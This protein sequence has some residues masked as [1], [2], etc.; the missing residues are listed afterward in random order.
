MNRLIESISKPLQVRSPKRL[1][2]PFTVIGVFNQNG[3]RYPEDVYVGAYQEIAPK[4]KERRLLGELDHPQDYDEVRLSNVSHVITECDIKDSS[5]KKV[6]YGTV[7]LLD[8]PAGK[9]A[10]ALV[11]AG[12]PLGISSR[13]V[14]NTKRVSEGVD[15]T[16]LKLI[17]Y[18][19]VAEPSFS[20]AILSEDKRTEL[21]ESLSVIES[22]LPL[23]ESAGSDAVRDQIYKIR[24]SLCTPKTSESTEVHIDKC[25]DTQTLEIEALKS[26]VESK[27]SV[28]VEDTRRLKESRKE[29]KS[30]RTQVSDLSTRYQSLTENHQKLQDSYNS[31]KK[32]Q[33][34]AEN[35]QIASLTEEVV[36]LRKRLAVEQRGMSYE[37]VQSFLEGVSTPEEI[38]SKLDSLSAMKRRSTV[39]ES[40]GR[41]R[42]SLETPPNRS[43][44]SNIVSKV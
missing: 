20:S 23:N 1:T 14:G 33:K 24:E 29:I 16:Q 36:D 17:T 9:V 39:V 19:L 44:L 22:K 4:I 26:I 41:V 28:I 27:K 37:Q 38:S 5:G 25:Q 31:L 21:E 32:S 13:A 10:Q 8:T 42:E 6:V 12:V 35:K 30:L 7:E 40:F 11:K 3:R 18:D 43:K 15:V 34:L 2:G